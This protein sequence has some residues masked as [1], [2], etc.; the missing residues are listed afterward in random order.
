MVYGRPLVIRSES[1]KKYKMPLVPMLPI[2]RDPR[3][4]QGVGDQPNAETVSNATAEAV[5]R[6]TSAPI[7]YVSNRK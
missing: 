5:K 2:S 7:E 6:P 4:L 1:D 3:A